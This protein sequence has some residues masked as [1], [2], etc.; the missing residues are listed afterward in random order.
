MLAKLPISFYVQSKTESN[1]TPISA[2]K[3]ESRCRRSLARETPAFDIKLRNY[4]TFHIFL[5][6]RIMDNLNFICHP[7]NALVY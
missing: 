6:N 3:L 4:I 7:I 2:N 5:P 1:L